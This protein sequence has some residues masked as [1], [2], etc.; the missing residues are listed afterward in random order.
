MKRNPWKTWTWVFEIAFLFLAL[1]APLN[2]ILTTKTS[3]FVWCFSMMAL[4]AIGALLAILKGYPPEEL[5]M[6]D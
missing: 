2:P 5:S 1:T 4:G 6:R 3:V